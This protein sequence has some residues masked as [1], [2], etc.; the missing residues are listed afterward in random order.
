MCNYYTTEIFGF[1][2]LN[3]GPSIQAHFNSRKHYSKK[4]YASI[5]IKII[6][7]N[8]KEIIVCNIM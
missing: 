1:E 4:Q 2:S 6:L 8:I 3:F 5:I 7:T